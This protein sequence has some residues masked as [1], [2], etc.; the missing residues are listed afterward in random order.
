MHSFAKP[1]V[2]IFNKTNAFVCIVV[3]SILQ[4]QFT[5]KGFK[6]AENSE[7]NV[8]LLLFL[9]T[10][11][12]TNALW[13]TVVWWSVTIL[14]TDGG[15]P[16]A[17]SRI[18]WAKLKHPPPLS[19]S[20]YFVKRCEGHNNVFKTPPFF[21]LQGAFWKVVK[22]VLGKSFFLDLPVHLIHV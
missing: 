20:L 2:P 6:K 18:A 22:V 21:S 14:R 15:F 13:K 8:V 10:L 12:K 5:E 17:F 16:D 7:Q 4:P 11:D 3:L 1:L 9:F 19:L